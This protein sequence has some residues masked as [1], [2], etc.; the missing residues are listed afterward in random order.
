MDFDN[1][2]VAYKNYLLALTHTHER[3]RQDHQENL[4][5]KQEAMT[6]SNEVEIDKDIDYVESNLNNWIKSRGDKIDQ[7]A[8]LD[9]YQAVGKDKEFKQV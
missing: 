3:M 1:A 2:P 9:F 4:P 5:K 8:I 7:M 6:A